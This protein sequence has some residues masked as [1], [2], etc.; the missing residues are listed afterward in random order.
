MYARQIMTANKEPQAKLTCCIIC[1]NAEDNVGRAI[2]S[3]QNQSR[4]PDE[5]LV[6]DDGSEDRTKEVVRGFEAKD[7][8]IRL[9]EQSSNHGV[10]VA[11]NTS[12]LCAKH[13]YIIFQDDDDESDPK[14]IEYQLKRLLDLEA[15]FP[16]HP[17]FVYC[18]RRVVTL[19]G[20]SHV[21]RSIH[22]PDGSLVRGELASR[23]F[24]KA[25]GNKRIS[26]LAGS[27][28]MMFNRTSLNTV[29]I[30]DPSFRRSAEIDLAVRAGLQG[31]VFS[32]VETPL[33]IQHKT[34]GNHKGKKKSFDSK[35]QLLNKHKD[36]LKKANLYYSSYL[37]IYSEYFSKSRYLFLFCYALIILS[38]VLSVRNRYFSAD[39]INNENT[40]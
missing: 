17:I 1:Y 40:I 28:T 2:E 13:D 31:G 20:Q 30:F 4:L 29:G 18:D 38:R 3:I 7:G 25:R 11:R 22:D 23:Y 9:I 16:N 26:G 32:S 14:R 36:Y 35:K 37:N 5:I 21:G 24:L 27:G 10:A 34:Q 19:D 8:R 33:L 39:R 6:V 15:E 12:I